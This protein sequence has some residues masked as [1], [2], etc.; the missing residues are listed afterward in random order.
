LFEIPP[1]ESI[2]AEPFLRD[3]ESQ[4]EQLAVDLG[5]PHKGFSIL[6]LR[7]RSRTSL[8]IR[9]R[10]PELAECRN[11]NFEFSALAG[12]Y[13][14]NLQYMSADWVQANFKKIFPVEFPA[15]CLSALDGLAFAPSLKPIFDEL[16]ASGVVDW[17]LRQEM[18]G[19][20]ARESLLQRMGLAYLGGQ[21]KLDGPR[22]AYLFE[23]RRISDLEELCQYFWMVRR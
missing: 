17:A 13:I 20:H 15:N 19:E 11:G 14:G 1:S 9:G 6:I 8:P 18:K 5:A 7:I 10:P 23:A 22:F 2:E 21:E 12:A 3:I 16:I 4:F